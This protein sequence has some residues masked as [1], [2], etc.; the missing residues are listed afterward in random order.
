MSTKAMDTPG[1]KLW[2]Q[3]DYM[4]RRA[5]MAQLGYDIM[6]AQAAAEKEWG[7]LGYEMQAKLEGRAEHLGMKQLVIGPKAKRWVKQADGT[8]KRMEKAAPSQQ[9]LKD[10]HTELTR[11]INPSPGRP[12]V[13]GNTL[14]YD[15]S[16]YHDE[17]DAKWFADAAVQQLAKVGIQ[18]SAQAKAS[19][20]THRDLFG[21]E[22]PVY[23][24]HVT[25]NDVK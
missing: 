8:I 20:K 10:A 21:N 22:A 5:T 3:L 1:S 6:S 17:D 14:I 2:G 12:R 24:V 18:A 11:R 13:S 23:D 7:A 4:Q 25:I 16:P 9:D 19:G 15:K